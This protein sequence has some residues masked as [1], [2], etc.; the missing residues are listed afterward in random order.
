MAHNI[1]IDLDG[2][3]FNWTLEYSRIIREVGGDTYPLITNDTEDNKDWD[4]VEWYPAP[5]EILDKAW[6][7]MTEK[8]HFWENIEVLNPDQV[9]YMCDKLNNHSNVNIYFISSRVACKG[10]TLVRQTVKSLEKIGWTSPQVIISF[11]KGALARALDL[12]YFLDDKAENC[13]EV[14]MYHRT[15]KVFVLDKF[16]NRILQ[17]KYFHIQRVTRL[18]EFTDI[19]AAGCA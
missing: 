14:A 7:V 10:D 5:K 11:N 3:Q 18:E 2:V 6:Q 17:D 12:K 13:A 19:V 1:G 16:Y 8:E 4:W 9:R 15:T